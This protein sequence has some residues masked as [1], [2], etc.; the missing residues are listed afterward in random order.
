MSI[1]SIPPDAVFFDMDG[2]LIDSEPLW[3][4]TEV[5]IV[6]EY[7][8][9]LGREHWVHVLGQPNEVAV[10]YL[11][12]VSGVPLTPVELNRRIE[13]AMEET[14]G[15]GIELVP[16][17]KQLLTDLN[18]AGL[19]LAL[20]SASSRRIVD[21]SLASIG[22]DHFAFTLS[23]D[24]VTHGKPHPEPYLTAA[25]RLGLAPE[26]CVVVEDSPNGAASGAAAGCR[27]LAVPQ[28]EALIEPHPL[29]TVA[30]PLAEITLERLRALFS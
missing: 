15:R 16:G 9:E 23:G 29:I 2:T 10:A 6:A 18:A 22:A 13:A 3:F 8:F 20:V 19:P 25:R 27:V 26:R 12:R 1:P 21:A 14:L 28:Q 4:D 5:S 24:D 17:A 11:L 7:G 30:G